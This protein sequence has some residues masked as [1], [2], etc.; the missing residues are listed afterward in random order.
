MIAISGELNR[1]KI[2]AQH[3]GNGHQMPR[4]NMPYEGFYPP[5]YTAY[6]I[7]PGGG[8]PGYMV[9]RGPMFNHGQMGFFQPMSGPTQH[10]PSGL[11]L[12]GSDQRTPHT[13]EAETSFPDHHRLSQE[14]QQQ[15][16]VLDAREGPSAPLYENAQQ[17]APSAS[18][19]SPTASD[20]GRFEKDPSSRFA[21]ATKK[22]IMKEVK[23][24]LKNVPKRAKCFRWDLMTE[25]HRGSGSPELTPYVHD[26][27]DRLE[28]EVRHLARS[29]TMMHA[30]TDR[31]EIILRIWK[32]LGRTI[33]IAQP[34]S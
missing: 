18:G 3:E 20:G 8:T 29:A 11:G 10:A 23:D 22:M 7:M 12:H 21:T 26:W 1:Q 13:T 17:R 9:E 25:Y 16:Q 2:Q 33:T 28:R 27:L 30:D 31:E 32:E 19:S 5:P 24:F 34:D 6:N 4:V 15:Q 14:Q